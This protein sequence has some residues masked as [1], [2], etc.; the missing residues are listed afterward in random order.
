MKKFS[1]LF[2]KKKSAT[3]QLNSDHIQT[4]DGQQLNRDHSQNSEPY[5]DISLDPDFKLMLAESQQGHW[6]ECRQL[7][8]ILDERYPGNSRIA[9]F[10]SD[11]ESQVTII[12]D[13]ASSAK[14]DKK[15]ALIHNLKVSAIIAGS[16]MATFLIIFFVSKEMANVS[17]EKQIQ[18]NAAQID[19]LNGQAEYLLDSGQP[20]K[21]EELLQKMK[22]IDPGNP[23]IVELSQKMDEIIRINALY[24]DAIDK[25]N[26]GLDSDGL[27]TLVRIESDYPGYKDVPQLIE[28]TNAKIK[29]TQ[30]L[31]AGAEAFNAGNW[32]ETI[33]KYELVLSL[34]PSN[35]DANLKGMLVYSYLLRINQLLE[36]TETAFAEI[37]QAGL[38]FSRAIVLIPQ[39]KVDSSELENLK[40]TSS[41][42]LELKYRQAA[43]QLVKDPA[44]TIDTVDL[45]NNYLNKA[46]SLNPQNSSLQSDVYKMNLYNTGFHYYNDMNWPAAIQQLSTLTAM[47]EGYPN[48][49]ARQLL[50]E[51]HIGQGRQYF[52]IG[53]YL[54]AREDYEIAE[55]IAAGSTNILSYYLADINLGSTLGKMNQYQYANSYFINAIQTINYEKR[56]LVTPAMKSSLNDAIDLNQAGQ[57]ENSFNIF[58]ETLVGNQTIYETKKINAFQGNCLALIAALNQSSVQAIYDLNN[59]PQQTILLSDQIL[60]IPAIP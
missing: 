8:S 34:D 59:L 10:K 45:A 39:S 18:E 20:E 42:L 13:I 41:N 16:I 25:L 2:N 38:Y 12:N 30:A 60:N 5:S 19:I 7:I 14:E 46:L 1:P 52:S 58:Y 35:S 6:N 37:N 11:F 51:A 23:K 31:N 53:S 28:S 17:R 33:D 48:D 56:A 9:E 36:N 54:D 57:Y 44:Q 21:A 27:S 22:A 43:D 15:N 26:K 55:T 4:P 3:N 47:D 49:F 29:I 24:L 32:Q 40:Q 50:Y